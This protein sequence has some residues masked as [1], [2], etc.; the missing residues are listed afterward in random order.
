MADDQVY[1]PL[2]PEE[3][4]Q[5]IDSFKVG[6]DLLTVTLIYGDTLIGGLEKSW[7]WN[8]ETINIGFNTKAGRR[9]GSSHIVVIPNE[10]VAN[11][12]LIPLSSE[13]IPRLEENDPQLEFLRELGLGEKVDRR[14]YVQDYPNPL[15]T[16]IEDNNI[17]VCKQRGLKLYGY[18]EAALSRESIPQEG[19]IFS[20]DFILYADWEFFSRQLHGAVTVSTNVPIAGVSKDIS[21]SLQAF[22]FKH[23][24]ENS[25]KIRRVQDKL[26][27]TG[28]N[29]I[30][31][32]G[33][34]LVPEPAEDTD[35][36]GE[37]C[38][39][40]YCANSKEEGEIAY[41]ALIKRKSL[42]YPLE[43]LGQVNS[44]LILYG[45][46]LPVPMDV[47]GTYHE[48]TI[49]ARAIGYLQT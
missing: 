31:V 33:C 1:Q 2:P 47:Y 37:N 40:V 17:N 32:Q 27:P 44:P 29:E 46:L 6:F 20:R 11:I 3:L 23:L 38:I 14:L 21:P 9:F 48:N 15:A 39:L 7:G 4:K 10:L 28:V 24:H 13:S 22:V 12:Y 35:I 30:F 8:G 42:K 45:E 49:L 16:I 36:E 34:I 19:I 18:V 25:Q 26:E 41:P 5:L 43:F